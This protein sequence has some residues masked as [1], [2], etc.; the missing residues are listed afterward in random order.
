MFFSDRA[1]EKLHKRKS[2]PAT[3]N[4]DLN[5]VRY[6]R[7]TSAAM[8]VQC[9]TLSGPLLRMCGWILANRRSVTT[10]AGTTSAASE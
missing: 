9:L 7:C 8:I 10:G 3:Y 4:L 2:V 5:L 1:M 6:S